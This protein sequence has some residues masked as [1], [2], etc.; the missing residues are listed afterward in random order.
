MKKII[1][2]TMILVLL[3]L[4]GCNGSQEN[5]ETYFCLDTV[6]TFTANCGREALSRANEKCREYENLLSRTIDTSE[7]G[8]LNKNGSAKV[9]DE[10]LK[11]IKTAVCY[12]DKTG[13]KF[14]ITICPVS[15]L[16]DFEGTSLPDRKEIAEA[17]KNVDYESIEITG[18][19]VDLNGKQIDLGAV[20]K[21]Y[22]ADQIV[23]VL[24]QNGA[25]KGIVNLGGNVAVFGKEYVIGIKKPFTEN[26]TVARLKIK[27]MSAVTSGIYERYIE[28]DGKIYHHILD[29]KT[30]YGVENTLASV[31]VIGKDGLSCDA[32]ST[33]LML[34]GK[35]EGLKL[36]NNTSG[37]EAVFV[38]KSGKITLS[39]GLIKKGSIIK[40]K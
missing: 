16:W 2:S 31:T 12:G 15:C 28:K 39:D 32:M 26:E 4:C 19:Q 34:L 30:G 40:K 29:T 23:K 7:I 5:S 3:L 11:L 6:A 14:D 33:S 8:R 10:T 36:I 13:G 35:Q 9:S 17:L 1:S 38:E 22:I 37:L 24:K 21:G 20:A 18:N 27:D 25:T